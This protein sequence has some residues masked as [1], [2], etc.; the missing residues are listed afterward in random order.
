MTCANRLPLHPALSAP[1]PRRWLIYLCPLLLL[2]ACAAPAPTR[3]TIDPPPANLAAPCWQ[4]PDWPAGGVVTLGQLLDVVAGREAAAA[5]CR[6]R[7][8][9]LVKAWP[10]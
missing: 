5:E 2:T 9:G 3:P 1:H 8:G 7:Q 10:Q 6:A 4:G